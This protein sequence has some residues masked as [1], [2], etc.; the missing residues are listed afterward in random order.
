MFEYS[1]LK[2]ILNSDIFLAVTGAHVSSLIILKL[3]LLWPA[4]TGFLIFRRLL[5]IGAGCVGACCAVSELG[6][7]LSDFERTRPTRKSSIFDEA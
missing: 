1:E 2:T 7:L 5:N 4:R 6:E 3:P